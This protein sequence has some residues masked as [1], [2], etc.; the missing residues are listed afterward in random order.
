[1]LF[2]IIL[3][4]LLAIIIWRLV[5]GLFINKS[6]RT[7]NGSQERSGKENSLDTKSIDYDNISDANFEDIDNKKF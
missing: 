3:Y 4:S 1:M 5:W 7:K 2:R 6:V